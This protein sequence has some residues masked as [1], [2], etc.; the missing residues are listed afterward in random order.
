VSGKAATTIDGTVS[1]AESKPTRVIS[2]RTSVRQ[3]FAD[4]WQYRELLV[5]LVRK[6]LKVK[7]KNSALGFFWSMLNPALYLVVF[8]V[9]FQLVLKN[10]I[11]YFAIYLLS[12]L[13]VWNLFSTALAAAT[14]AV[15]GNA[16]IV[17]KVSFPREIL[18]LAAVG[19]SLVHFFLQ[20]CVLILALAGF[21]YAPS[22]T[23]LPLVPVALVALI[24]LASALGVFLAAV[25]VYARD[26]QHLL[27]LVLLAWFWMTPIV[28]Q[29]RL[30]ADRLGG[31]AWLYRLNPVT[32]VVLTFQRAIYNRTEPVGTGGQRIAILPVD[33]GPM[34]YL[35]QLLAVLVLGAVLLSMAMKLFGRLEGNF[36][37]EL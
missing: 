23:F 20:A 37:E 24:V 29:Y 1:R 34:W 26:T 2:S 3:R 16:A 21:R 4:I 28:Y 31:K 19:A 13:L 7:Y 35:V 9:V 12:G 10:G 33:A 6:E 30:V 14:G 32:P 22:P 11:P 17:K 5:G 15:V 8:Y 27:E 36:A 18:A 25:N